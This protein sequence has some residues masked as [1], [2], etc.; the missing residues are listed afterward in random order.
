M[1][2]VIEIERELYIKEIEGNNF[3]QIRKLVKMLLGLPP[4]WVAGVAFD[5]GDVVPFAAQLKFPCGRAFH[6]VRTTIEPQKEFF[7]WL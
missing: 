5:E 6:C 1:K 2:I 4:H 7:V 3:C